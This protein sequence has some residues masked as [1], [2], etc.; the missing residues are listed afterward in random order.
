[1]RRGFRPWDNDVSNGNTARFDYAVAQAAHAP[2]LLDP[3][4]VRESKVAT[5]SSTDNIA[6][7]HHCL[8]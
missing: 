1:M 8:D 4:L 6:I 5:E 3:V 7:E 2:H